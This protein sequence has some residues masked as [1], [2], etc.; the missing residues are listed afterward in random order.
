MSLLVHKVYA[1][2]QFVNSNLLLTTRN[3]IISCVCFFLAI[4]NKKKKYILIFFSY[5]VLSCL[6]F[7]TC[8][9]QG[10]EPQASPL[11]L[12]ITFAINK[13]LKFE[14]EFSLYFFTQS[15]GNLLSM[16]C[17]HEA[18]YWPPL[19]KIESHSSKASF[20]PCLLRISKMT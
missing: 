9:L 2:C 3:D 8:S 12:N 7:L 17:N 1:C 19:P 4:F 18:C 16:I 11:S 6:I 15:R 10:S 14:P 13:R 5:F 20:P